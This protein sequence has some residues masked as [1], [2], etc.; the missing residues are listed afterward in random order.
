MTAFAAN[1]FRRAE[2]WPAIADVE[3]C[4]RTLHRGL[5]RSYRRI[6]ADLPRVKCQMRWN[7]QALM[8]TRA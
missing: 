2:E 4:R 3:P 8:I 6:E 1:P 7:I 5:L